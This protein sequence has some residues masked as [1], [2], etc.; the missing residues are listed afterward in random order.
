MKGG[1]K[2]VLLVL[3]DQ[4]FADAMSCRMGSQY[5]HTPIMDEL[6]ARGTLFTKAYTPHPLCVPARASII[7]GQ[8]PHELGIMNLAAYPRL[9]NPG[10]L[11]DHQRYPSIGTHFRNCGYATAYVGKWHVP[12]DINDP[13]VSGFDF[14]ENIVIKKM[15]IRHDVHS[16]NGVDLKNVETISGFLKQ[17][18]DRPFFAVVSFNNPHNICEWARNQFRDNMPDGDVGTPPAVEECPPVPVNL[19]QP[20]DEVD[21]LV[22]MREESDRRRSAF[23]NDAEWRIYLWAYY[24][25][26][27]L[28][29]RRL[30]ELMQVLRDTGQEDDTVI[31]FT[32][33]H[34][35]AG[36]AHSWNQKRV[37]Y[38]ESSRVPFILVGPGVAGGVTSDVL[39]QTG[40]DTFPTLCRAAGV[41]CPEGLPGLDVRSPAIAE[42]S[43]IIC[44]TTF[45][46]N[47]EVDP[48]QGDIHGH[49]V[50]SHRFKYCVYDTGEHRESLYDIDQDPGEMKNLARDPAHADTLQWHRDRHRE[51]FGEAF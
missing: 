1:K 45:R 41:D 33:D 17:E 25:M 31:V 18:R 49:M 14:A 30:G 40:I 38:E 34:G 37:F 32:S 46:K 43:H 3:T 22:Q 50:R 27:E 23:L 16:H 2:N 24:R 4:Q 51:M 21:I 10:K 36:G 19:A 29:D 7:T 20:E 15:Q 39:V 28:V 9:G 44:T 11:V 26:I 42:R 5:I 6:A 47:S 13:G 35:D 8:Y 12:L 48:Q